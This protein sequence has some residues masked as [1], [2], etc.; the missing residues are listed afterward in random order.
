MPCDLVF[1]FYGKDLS[2]G[3]GQG[4]MGMADMVSAYAKQRLKARNQQVPAE[5]C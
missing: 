2:M 5:K 1:E 3:K 4:L